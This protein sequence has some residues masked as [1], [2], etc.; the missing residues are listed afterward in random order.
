MNRPDD[1]PAVP[2]YI[3]SWE[4]PEDELTEKYP[5]Q[6]IGWHSRRSTHS[7]FANLDR[8]HKTEALAVWINPRD[9]EERG[10]RDG[11]L[12]RVWNDRGTVEIPARVTE[13][14]MQGVAAMPQGGWYLPDQNGVDRGSSINTLTGF[15]PTP[16]AKGNSQHTILVEISP[17][18]T[19][20]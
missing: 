14:I 1:I 17:S 13:D 3:P 19:P 7:T 9:A 12:V 6:L 11:G 16:L 5:L 4:G 10:I 18:K 8:A 20:G 15:K 2:K